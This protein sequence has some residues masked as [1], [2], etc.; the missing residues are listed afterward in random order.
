[1]SNE[2]YR[3]DVRCHGSKEQQEYGYTRR[4]LTNGSLMYVPNA[5]A[6]DWISNAMRCGIMYAICIFF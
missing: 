3:I 1:M 4:E 2:E 5:I 6:I